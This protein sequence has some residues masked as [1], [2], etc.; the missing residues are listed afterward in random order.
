MQSRSLKSRFDVVLFDID[1]VLVDTRASYLAAIQKTVEIYLNRPGVVS[2]QDI[3]RF[4]LLGGFNDDWDACFGLIAFLETS[5]Q[6]KPIRF[7]DH[8]RYRLSVSELGELFPERPLGV[9][10]LLKKLR[11]LYEHVEIPS[12]QKIAR[13]FQEVYLGKKS[14]GLIRKEKPIFSKSTLEKIHA[15]GIRMGIVTG[16]NQFEARYALKRFGTLKLFDVL[17]TIDEVKR[18]EK[19]TGKILRKPNPWPVLEAARQLGGVTASARLKPGT[20]SNASSLRFLYVGDLP[21]DILAAKGAGGKISIRAAAFP[22]YARDPDAITK[23][24][25]KVKPDFL[26]KKPE[27]LL[28]ILR[29]RRGRRMTEMSNRCC[30]DP[31]RR[32]SQKGEWRTRGRPVPSHRTASGTVRGGSPGR[33]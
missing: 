7:G 8:R 30:E 20:G 16:R 1:N 6:G 22:A 15:K 21:D 10:G 19:K 23:E 12:Y 5:I 31:A 13:I 24:L 27:D 29:P 4:K 25:R 33:S 11:V 9:E 14:R 17:V 18:A 26:L 2:P 32:R 3:D 28:V